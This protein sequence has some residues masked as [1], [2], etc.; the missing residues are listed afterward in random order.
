MYTQPLLD[1]REG[2]WSGHEDALP[3]RTAVVDTDADAAWAAAAAARN[4]FADA[5]S[6]T[7][8][9]ERPTVPRVVADDDYE[10]DMELEPVTGTEPDV[11]LA[12]PL[13]APAGELS[14]ATRDAEAA[15][16]RAVAARNGFGD[17]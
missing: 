11:N 10:L 1:R 12:A 13:D 9:P 16:A 15:W 8:T 17:F 6:I 5:P 14:Q 3:E 2:D 7:Q 4:G